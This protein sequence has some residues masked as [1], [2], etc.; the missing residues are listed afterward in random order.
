MCIGEYLDLRGGRFRQEAGENYTMRGAHNLYLAPN[1][2][3]LIKSMRIGWVRNV[4][5]MRR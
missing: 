3:G 5:Y 4:T 1:I 2:I